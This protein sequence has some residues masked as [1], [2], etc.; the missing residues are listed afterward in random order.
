MTGPFR[1]G[2]WQVNPPLRTLSSDRGRLHLEPKQMQVL[3]LL[4]QRAGELVSKESLLKTV[5]PDTFVGD[6]VLSK[7]VSEL[8]RA[9]NDDPRAPRFIQTIPKG[10]YRLVAPVWFDGRAE[11]PSLETAEGLARAAGEGGGGDA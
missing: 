7:A 5:W 8:R 3:V 11:A 4:A 10:G 9:L 6:E 2:D 1:I